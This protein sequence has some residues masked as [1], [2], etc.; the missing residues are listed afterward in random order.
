MLRNFFYGQ[1]PLRQAFWQLSVLGLTILGFISRLLMIQLKQRMNYDT[2]FIQ[3]ALKSLS[4]VRMDTISLAVFSFYVAA[5]LGLIAYSILCIGGMWNTYKEYDKSKT[6]ALI[7]LFV[8]FILAAYMI[9]SAI[10]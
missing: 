9:K 6:L 10:Y 8:V 7:C 4:F 5:F 3:V 2:N 1:L